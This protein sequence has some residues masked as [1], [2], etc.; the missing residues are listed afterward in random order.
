VTAHTMEFLLSKVQVANDAGKDL[1]TQTG[2]M[3]SMITT[4]MNEGISRGNSPI[5]GVTLGT[6]D[7]PVYPWDGTTPWTFSDVYQ[8]KLVY[9]NLFS[10]I[11]TFSDVTRA[12]W[13]IDYNGV[14]N[15]KQQIGADRTDVAFKYGKGGN[16]VA[17]DSPLDGSNMVNDFMLI[18][19]SQDG[20][21]LVK[22]PKNDTS[23]YSLYG[24]LWGVKGISDMISQNFSDQKAQHI[25]NLNKSFDTQL[26]LD[27]AGNAMPVGSWDLGDKVN[28]D[29]QDGPISFNKKV[30]I[31]GWKT[32]VS[33]LGVERTQLITNQDF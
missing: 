12:D 7:N 4:L 11:N 17:F 2:T 27:L 3:S 22:S 6:I 16:V 14:F 33:D 21:N 28:V 26:F 30:R 1:R 10:A 9:S 23:T 19:Q 31:I 32:T 24:D 15:F 29:I 8:F 13:N 20:S 18:A 25:F 5:A